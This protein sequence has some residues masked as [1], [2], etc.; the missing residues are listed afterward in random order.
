M[1]ADLVERPNIPQTFVHDLESFFWVLLWIVLTRV[2]TSWTEGTRL[3]IHEVMNPKVYENGSGGRQKTIF[4][5]AKYELSKKIFQIPGDPTLRDFLEGLYLLVATRYHD[6]PVKHRNTFAKPMT[7]EEFDEAVK[8][9]ERHMGYLKD[10]SAMINDFRM[11]LDIMAGPQRLVPPDSVIQA[12][13]S[14]SKRSRD[15]VEDTYNQTLSN[16]RRR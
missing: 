12:S 1:A 5:T 13:N 14:G 2:Q 15:M 10:H 6:L 4:L 8:T 7:Q 9:H 3:F 11:A 16:K